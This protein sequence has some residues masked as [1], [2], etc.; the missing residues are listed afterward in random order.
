MQSHKRPDDEKTH[1]AL[2][3]GGNREACSRGEEERGKEPG[4]DLSPGAPVLWGPRLE[5]EGGQRLF[6]GRMFSSCRISVYILY[7]HGHRFPRV[8]SAALCYFY[9][10]T[11]AVAAVAA[12]VAAVTA[13]AAAATGCH[14]ELNGFPAAFR[15]WLF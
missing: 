14:W 15:V 6:P 2:R 1:T 13:A 3:A 5:G 4:W 7:S 9:A 8:V 10:A 12:V 11:T